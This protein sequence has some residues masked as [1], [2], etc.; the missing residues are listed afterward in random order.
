[1]LPGPS[2]D[3]QI[4]TQSRLEH[5]ITFADPHTE[6]FDIGLD[7]GVPVVEGAG[8]QQRVQRDPEKGLDRSRAYREATPG[9]DDAV[10]IERLFI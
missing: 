4:V 2:L 3:G 5:T 6:G 9:R 1:M 10:R 8:R 7:T